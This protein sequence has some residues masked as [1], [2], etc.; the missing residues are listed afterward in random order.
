MKTLAGGTMKTRA[1]LIL[2]TLLTGCLRPG[3][4]RAQLDRE[5]G[6]TE[7][8]GLELTVRDGLATFRELETRDDGFVVALWAQAPALT[9]DLN[10]P[11][12]TTLEL[13]V[14]NTLVDAVLTV[15]DDA[16]TP[17]DE[18]DLPTVRRWQVAV[19]A[20][21][22]TL[23]IASP[24][25]D[26]VSA[27]RVALMSDV[28]SAL[29]EVGDI[30]AVMNRDPT[31]RFVVS[32]GD[33]VNTGTPDE[34]AEFQARLEALNVPLY[35]TPGNHERGAD[36]AAWRDAFGRGSFQFRFK[37]AFFTFADSSAATVD[38][39]VYGWLKGWLADASD[40]VHLFMTH[41]PP[42][43]PE[44]GRNGG[45]RSRREAAKMFTLLARGRVDAAV[46]GHVHSLYS[47]SNAGVDA[48]ISGGGGALPERLDGIGR[49]F[50]LADIGPERVEGVSVV[51]VD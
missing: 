6:R 18:A 2:L 25:A 1:C 22:S 27:F 36:E 3:L 49:H 11:A 44:G 35:A 33:L 13:T 30:Y 47:Y 29:P 8:D 10:A 51:R 21:P 4:D 26:E 46:Y 15:D 32:S 5:V 42:I 39:V 28:Q 20:G 23:R 19:P 9:I 50:L 31:I 16:V 7:I 41:V 48:W 24:D 38:P 43:D 12:A 14:R 37:G 34:L 45:W 17:A 40:A